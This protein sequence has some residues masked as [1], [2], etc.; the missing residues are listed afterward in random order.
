MKPVVETLAMLL[1]MT[2]SSRA[3][4]V[5]AETPT[6]SAFCM[7]CLEWRRVHAL[8]RR[9]CANPGNFV[10]TLIFSTLTETKPY[11]DTGPPGDGGK[12]DPASSAA[13]TEG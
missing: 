2:S 6:K 12:S 5:W 13:L 11:A 4:A 8:H 9:G 3:R 1:A 7:V 10:F